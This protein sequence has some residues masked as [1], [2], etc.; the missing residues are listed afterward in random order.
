MS[1]KPD[2]EDYEI[3]IE[4]L[5]EIQEEMANGLREFEEICKKYASMGLPVANYE[6]YVFAQL[7]IAI[8]DDHGFATRDP[9]L[10]E[11]ITDMESLQFDFGDDGH[12]F[13]RLRMAKCDHITARR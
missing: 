4:R 10:S 3:D 13:S 7:K 1:N 5:R 2:Y 8:S 12:R 11:V 6:A 9:N